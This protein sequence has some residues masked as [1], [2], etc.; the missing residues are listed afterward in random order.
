MAQAMVNFRMDSEEKR[1]FEEVCEQLGLTITS[2]LRMFA[3]KVIREKRIPFDVALEKE[4]SD[5]F[6]SEEN[7]SRLRESIK[8]AKEGKLT[9]HE[10]IEVE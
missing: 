10:L 4:K 5:P 3:K 9:Q 1:S 6:W 7:Q 2:T 8:H